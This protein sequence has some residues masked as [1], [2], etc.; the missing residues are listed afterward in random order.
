MRTDPGEVDRALR[1]WH[2]VCGEA[3]ES[4]AIDGKTLRNARDEQGR[5]NRGHWSIE[6]GCH[7]T[8]DR[9]FDEE[10]SRIRTGHGP[11]N[12]SRL[13]RFASERLP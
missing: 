7:Y 10:R 4:L 8:I 1:G 2:E 11:E 5:T 9:N 12:V 6:N 3:D 13:R